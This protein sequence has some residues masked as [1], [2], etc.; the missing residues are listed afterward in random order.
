MRLTTPRRLRRLAVLPAATLLLAGCGGGFGADDD[1]DRDDQNQGNASLTVLIGSSGPAETQAVQAAAARFADTTGNQVEVIPAQD[2]VQQLQ[3]GFTGGEPPDVFYVSPD[4]FQLY[5]EGGSLHPYGD[6]IE[7]VDDFYPALRQAFTYQD[8]LYC[9]PK[10]GGAHALVID[11]DAWEEAGLTDA[12][13]PQTWQDLTRVAGELTTDDRVGLAFNGDYNTVGTFLLG[14][15][16]FYVNPDQ[17]QVTADTPANAATLQFILDNIDAGVF[18]FVAD[19]DSGWGGEALGTGA[20]AMTVEGPWIAGALAA[21]WPDRNWRAVEMPPGPAGQAVGA[22]TNCWGIAEQSPSKEAA[23]DLVRHF[24]AAEEQQTFMQAFGPHPS[25]A[26]LQQWAADESPDQVAF[27]AGLAYGRT[28]VAI[29]GFDSVL[30]DFNAQLQAMRLGDVT[31]AEALAAL[32][33]NGE[34]VLAQG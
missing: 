4:R 30:N 27:A 9:L 5:A 15:G 11:T 29:P 22:F 8:Q 1:S 24:T 28:Q 20:S 23:V 31:P 13:L 6:Q 3:Q 12:D 14:G 2:L 18:A 10:D 34:A 16:G 21:D 7:D 17:T 32:Q 25:R 33:D 19:V 26:S